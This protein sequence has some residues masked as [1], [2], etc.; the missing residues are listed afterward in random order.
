MAK[1]LLIR[2]NSVL[3]QMIPPLGLAYLAASLKDSYEVK[4]I[5]ALL[6]RSGSPEVKEE[7]FK[8]RPDFVGIT[9]WHI[10][11]VASHEIAGV[12]KSFNP[13]CKVIIGGPYA[14]VSARRVLGDKNVDFAVIGEGE[15]VLKRL[16]EDIVKGE[17]VS[18]LNGV[19]LRQD[20][21]FTLNYPAEYIANIDEI[22]FPAWELFDI[23]SYLGY[24][25]N[26]FNFYRYR[27]KRIMPFLTS[28]GCPLNCRFCAS[29]FG[30]N[31]RY[32]SIEN[33]LQELKIYLGKYRIEG[34]DI[35][36]DNFSFNT[37]RAFEVLDAIA[38][39][40]IKLD[41]VFGS[42]LMTQLMSKEFIHKLKKAGTTS[43]IYGIG[44]V[45]EKT[46]NK[47]NER[48]DVNKAKEIISHTAGEGIISEGVFGMGYPGEDKKDIRK[49]SRTARGMKFDSV[50][51]FNGSLGMPAGIR[52]EVF[53]SEECLSRPTVRREMVRA[54]LLFYFSPGRIKSIFKIIRSF[55]HPF[56][57]LT[58][59]LRMVA[60]LRF[61]KGGN[62]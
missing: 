38:A 6:S 39:E 55:K 8:F 1:V 3:K 42:G 12:V 50:T 46:Q 11:A 51:F 13:G 43:V 57:C 62:V 19:A 30:K 5:D 29:A 37:E 15:S 54:Y 31:L 61:R 40:N 53:P 48:F 35:V 17:D 56:R 28:R 18:S 36:D 60:G 27:G 25:K 47:L 26:N 32:R 34:I 45:L 7:I 14:T 49:I 10:S 59:G 16:I 4:V 24:S 33:I 9:S 23:E 21:A 20:A 52:E 44:P 58:A 41:I 22:K 2:P